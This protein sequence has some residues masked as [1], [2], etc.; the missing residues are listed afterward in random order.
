[1]LESLEP[2]LRQSQTLF[3]K[4]RFL[5]IINRITPPQLIYQ[6]DHTMSRRIYYAVQ[7]P[8]IGGVSGLFQSVAFNTSIDFEQVFELGTLGQIEDIEGIPQAEITGE[9]A[10]PISGNTMWGASTGSKG[11][12]AACQFIASAVIAGSVNVVPDNNTTGSATRLVNITGVVSN[13]SQNYAV[14][15]PAT[16]SMTIVAD[17]IAWGGGGGG[18][19]GANSLPTPTTKVLS[20]KNISSVGCVQSASFNV[21]LSREDIMC[22]GKKMPEFK[23]A[24]FPIE[25]SADIEELAT[26][27][28]S[29]FAFTQGTTG[30]VTSSESVAFGLGSLGNARTTGS[31]FSGGDSGGGNM[32]VTKSFIAFNSFD[33][34]R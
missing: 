1:M 19:G 24:Q 10:I 31:S 16:E 7:S 29:S 3:S 33:S 15:G 30:D 5:C 2:L 13:Y 14:E 22:L 32:S 25:C 27:G 6:G 4:T 26:A 11:A 21:D 20:R 34:S 23:A 18:V 9:R 28:S 8:V 12:A 17:T